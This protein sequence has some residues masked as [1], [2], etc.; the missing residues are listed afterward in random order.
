MKLRIAHM[1]PEILNLYGDFGNIISLKK[2]AEWRNIEVE[3]SEYAL[4]DEVD[5]NNIDILFIGG[6]SDKEQIL[7]CEKLKEHKNE[8]K[9]YVEN[10]GVLLA[11]CSGYEILGNRFS[12]NGN[13][14]TGLGILDMCTEH[15]NSRLISDVVIKTSF[16][17]RPV[18]GFENHSGR[19][20]IGN[21]SDCSLGEVI[22]GN[23]NNGEDGKEGMVYKNVFGTY[24]HGPLFPKNPHLCDY[25]IKKALQNKYGEV[26]LQELNDEIEFLANEY[27][28]N[29]FSN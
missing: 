10:N 3:I 8:I 26:V 23:G 20:F 19:T 21:D 28:V 18:V 14:Y 6:G 11:F 29:R 16:L 27:I 4:N 17:D 5:F 22:Y 2:R 1:Y 15:K 12:L 9:K 24:L 7:V 25:I 13:T